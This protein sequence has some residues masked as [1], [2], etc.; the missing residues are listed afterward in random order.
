M[1]DGATLQGPFRTL[2]GEAALPVL[3]DT[4]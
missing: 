2:R 3:D 1:Y 4:A